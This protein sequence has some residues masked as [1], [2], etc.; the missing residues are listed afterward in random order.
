M[1][2]SPIITL[3]FPEPSQGQL[4][5]APNLI[6]PPLIDQ[7]CEIFRK[8]IV[9][10]KLPNRDVL[11]QGTSLPKI[12]W[13]DQAVL[14]DELMGQRQVAAI[15]QILKP[16]LFAGYPPGVSDHVTGISTFTNFFNIVCAPE[17]FENIK[18]AAASNDPYF[19]NSVILNT[20]I[21]LGLVL[22]G[23]AYGP[24]RV[25]SVIAALE[26]LDP[27]INATTAVGK[28]AF[29]TGV[30]GDIFFTGLL[31]GGLLISSAR[32]WNLSSKFLSELRGIKDL[33]SQVEFLFKKISEKGPTQ[34]TKTASKE[35][36]SDEDFKKLGEEKCEELYKFLLKTFLDHDH[37]IK[38]MEEAF[39]ESP[40]NIKRSI[41]NLFRKLRRDEQTL[42]MVGKQW[43]AENDRAIREAELQNAA[44]VSSA[45]KVHDAYNQALHLRLESTDEKIRTDAENK[46]EELVSQTVD[47]AKRVRWTHQLW[48]LVGLI[49]VVSGV[50][51]LV[52][53]FAP[54]VAA[55]WPAFVPILIAALL[56]VLIIAMTK[57]DHDSWK[58]AMEKAPGEWDKFLNRLTTAILVSSIIVTVA[59]W[60][61]FSLSPIGCALSLGGAIVA[62]GLRIYH[63]SQ[64]HKRQRLWNEKHPTLSTL[65][66]SL[67]TKTFKALSTEEKKAKLDES[68]E[69]LSQQDQEILLTTYIANTQQ[70]GVMRSAQVQEDILKKAIEKTCR[71]VRQWHVNAP[72]DSG[73]KKM[74]E[75]VGRIFIEIENVKKA[76]VAL[77]LAQEALAHQKTMMEKMREALN[78][79]V[80]FVK[81]KDVPVVDYTCEIQKATLAFETAQKTW[82][83]EFNELLEMEQKIIYAY[84]QSVEDLHNEKVLG[85]MLE[86]AKKEKIRRLEATQDLLTTIEQ[87]AADAIIRHAHIV[88]P[89]QQHNLNRDH[90]HKRPRA[91]FAT[92][93]DSE[94]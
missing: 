72:T 9:P 73:R 25:F 14:N 49:G 29:A 51:G 8:M 6:Q 60:V 26:G 86:L 37:T 30:G 27:S 87:T 39:R 71:A 64:L 21:W 76:E 74:A 90:S 22:G 78:G 44:G 69:L 20:A 83:E 85:P 88:H 46:A 2:T 91:R 53:A 84:Y 43:K 65:V 28:A 68:L 48:A 1:A 41:T 61:V 75:K 17:V 5:V 34:S 18:A 32:G 35:V 59:L 13:N 67:E 16:E 62:L 15:L 50:L 55:A 31:Y 3:F 19:Q 82:R 79:L 63:Y 89:V 80:Q 24:Y 81:G 12:T 47:A 7:I 54:A 66:N 45:R 52:A 58:Q 94:V 11:H 38:G 42:I 57:L 4:S 10:L 93:G 33:K 92:V 70:F 23:A 40:E 56:T 36:T 77:E